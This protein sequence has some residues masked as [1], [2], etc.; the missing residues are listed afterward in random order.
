[1]EALEGECVIGT[2]D[3]PVQEEAVVGELIAYTI[4]AV[5]DRKAWSKFVTDLISD[6]RSSLIRI[7]STNT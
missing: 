1:M 5:L 7:S 3:G 6:N 4:V 2:A